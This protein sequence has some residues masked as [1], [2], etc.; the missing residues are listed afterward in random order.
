MITLPSELVPVMTIVESSTLAAVPPTVTLKAL[1]TSGFEIPDVIVCG[2]VVE[3]VEAK[4]A[5]AVPA[6]T[7]FIAEV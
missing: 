7:F 3:A 5:V 6:E 2:E 1:G 4:I